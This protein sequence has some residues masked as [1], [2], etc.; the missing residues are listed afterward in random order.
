M[1]LHEAEQLARQLMDQHGVTADGWVFAWSNGK[2]QLGCAQV[3]RRRDPRTRK[4]VETKSIKLSR[5]LVRLNDEDEVRDTILHEIAHA[6]A[7]IEHGH[8][9]TW[10]AV[11]RR[12]GARPQRLAGEEVNVVEARYTLMCGTCDKALGKRHRR[13]R[14]ERLAISYC[15]GCGRKSK[16]TL[17]LHDSRTMEPLE[18]SLS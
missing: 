14:K 1:L 3:R 5:H 8:D 2:R 7:G 16:G 9:A 17:W 4:I 13:I 12:I 18:T 11:C 10:K 6:I 15:R